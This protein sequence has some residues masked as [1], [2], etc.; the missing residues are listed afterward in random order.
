[1]NRIFNFLSYSFLHKTEPED[2]LNLPVVES[3]YEENAE[4]STIDYSMGSIANM[5][6]IAQAVTPRNYSTQNSTPL[7]VI[8]N[9]TVSEKTTITHELPENC[10][11]D[12]S[13]SISESQP[14]PIQFEEPRSE[15]EAPESLISERMV[16]MICGDLEVASVEML[17]LNVHN[18]T[19]EMHSESE[20]NSQGS[21]C[22]EASQTTNIVEPD[23]Q[24]IFDDPCLSSGNNNSS[25]FC[26][27]LNVN[28]LF[29]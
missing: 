7:M 26:F 11:I 21:V 3:I 24:L 2:I 18:D 23:R 8:V 1:M 16:K 5:S 10:L 12:S 4:Q 28:S 14:V 9:E 17:N 29:F 22:L 6:E 19:F 13:M 15:T 25:F 20:K 27:I